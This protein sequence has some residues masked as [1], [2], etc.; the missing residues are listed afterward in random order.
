MEFKALCIDINLKWL[1]S[2]SAVKEKEHIRVKLTR[3]AWQILDKLTVKILPK[4]MCHVFN[5]HC[6]LDC[7]VSDSPK[8]CLPAQIPLSNRFYVLS[9]DD[10]EE[11]CSEFDEMSLSITNIKK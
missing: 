4:Y 10:L 8:K 5:W 1:S 2:C 9:C 7:S 6:E 11:S 3:K